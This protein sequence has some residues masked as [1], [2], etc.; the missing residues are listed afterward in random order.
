MLHFGDSI[1]ELKR[2]FEIA[3]RFLYSLLFVLQGYLA[4]IMKK[5][6]NVSKIRNIGVSAHIDSGKTTLTERL[7]FNTGRISHMH[8]QQQ[9][10]LIGKIQT[11]TLLTLQD[12]WTLLLKW[13]D[14]FVFLMVPFKCY[15]QLVGCRMGA[16]P[17]R[18]LSQI[19]AKLQHT[20]AFTQLPIGLE[21]D[22]K[23]VIDLVRWKA[24]YFEG[25]QGSK[26]VEGSIPEDM[27]NE[28]TKRRQELI[29]TIA[30][31][32]EV[33]GEM[34][35]EEIQ[36]TE[37]QLIAAICRATIKRSFTPVF[38]GSALK[39]KGIQWDQ[40][41]EYRT[42]ANPGFHEAVGDTMSLSVDTPQHLKKIG[43]L[44]SVSNY[45][46]SDI[47][48]LMKMAL[49]KIAFRPFGF[50]IDQWRW[51]VFSGKITDEN[52]NAEWWKLRTKY[53]GIKPAVE[54]SEADFDPGCK[55][56]IPANTPYI[57]YFMSFVLQFQFH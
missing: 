6:K 15:V 2:R 13:S 56:H 22:L 9:H 45:T 53:Q 4:L 14:L 27:L 54:W 29:E 25:E 51:K 28:C 26:V 12:T 18:V 47:N 52:Y 42:G 41:F 49:R 17:A 7:L 37:E 33:L 38:V 46:E 34:F 10:M 20:A 40:P 32:D 3:S 1:H 57:R 11:S 16:N 36:P 35:L 8:S 55:Y 30:D 43:L 48:A 19:R 21:S 31:V 44:E 39:N 50:L 23:G 5:K 24:Y